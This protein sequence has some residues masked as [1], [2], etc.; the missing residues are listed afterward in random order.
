MVVFSGW[1]FGCV[2][3]CPC[4]VLE[5]FGVGVRVLREILGVVGVFFGMGWVCVLGG[6]G[7]ACA[8]G[9]CGACAGHSLEPGISSRLGVAFWPKLA[10]LAQ[11]SEKNRIFDFKLRS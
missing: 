8:S 10:K 1:L 7:F 4:I 2:K 9:A 3:G 5:R 11:D 6:L